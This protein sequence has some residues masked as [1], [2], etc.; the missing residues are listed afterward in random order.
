MKGTPIGSEHSERVSGQRTTTFLSDVR[1]LP[2]VERDRPLS[3]MVA[4]WLAN[5]ETREEILEQLEERGDDAA[6]VSTLYRLFDE[7][8]ELVYVGITNV[9]RHRL[10]QHA[11]DK[12]WWADVKSATFEHF[13]TRDE[14]L[15]AETKAIKTESPKA[16]IAG[17]PR[18]HVIMP[19]PPRDTRSSVKGLKKADHYKPSLIAQEDIRRALDKQAHRHFDCDAD[20]LI[21]RFESGEIERTDPRLKYVVNLMGAL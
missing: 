2:V 9:G 20:E 4:D 18:P 13:K 10:K 14:A 11:A 16:N 17:R 5:P 19:T 8:G 1:E 21:R 15:A 3:G 7:A 6:R 12:E